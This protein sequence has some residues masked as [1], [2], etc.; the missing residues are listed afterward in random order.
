[1]VSDDKLFEIIENHHG[2]DPKILAAIEN[3]WNGK[4]I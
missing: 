1:M 2:D 4:I 3:M